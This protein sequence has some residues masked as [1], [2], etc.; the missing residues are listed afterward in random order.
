MLLRNLFSRQ[1]WLVT[2]VVIAGALGLGRLG[3]WQLDRLKERRAFNAQYITIHSQ[4]VLDLTQSQPANLISMEWR[5]VEFTGKYDFANQIAIRNQYYNGQAGYHLMTPLLSNGMAVLVDRGWIPADGNS[6]PIAWRQYD[7]AGEVKVVGEIR[8]GSGKPIFGGVA[9]TLPVNGSK[10]AIWNNA[11]VVQVA[12]QI[13]YPILPVYL[14][15]HA[16][17]SDTQ[18]PI[19]FQSEV[20]LTEGPHFGYAMQWFSFATILLVGYSYYVQKQESKTR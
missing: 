1:W 19:P 20:D 14:E 2:L 3:I 9:D 12:K 5:P 8:I 15:P 13:P 17:A 10:L 6:V 4:A 11:D 18:P 16:D 7:V